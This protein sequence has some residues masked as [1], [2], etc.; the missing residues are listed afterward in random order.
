M[1]GQDQYAGKTIMIFGAGI[2]QLELIKSARDMVI[3][4][5]VVDPQ[6][7]PPGKDIA[8]FYY[9]I[10]ANDYETTREIAV[11]HKI[12]GLVTTQMEKP[13]RLM[14]RLAEDLGLKFHSA[15]VV[16]RSLDKW[17]MKQAFLQHRVP[18]AHGKLFTLE[19]QVKEMDLCDFQYPLILKPKDGTS[20][21]GV[22]RI[23]NYADIVKYI[24][25]TH[26]YS[27]NG[28]VLIEEFIEGPEYSIESITFNG[29]TTI[30]QYTEKMITPFP[31]TVEMGH[32]QPADLTIQQKEMIASVVK[33]AIQAIGIDNSAAHTEVK[34]TKDGPKVLEIGA[35][36]GGDLI[37]SFLTFGSTGVSMDKAMIQIALN[38]Q[39]DLE[40]K[41]QSYSHIKYFEL[42]VGKK[43]LQVNDW[44]DVLTESTL[45][46][47]DISVKPGDMIEEITES[48]KRPGFVI[49]KGENRASVLNAA[50]I[51]CEKL[52]LKV[53]LNGID[54]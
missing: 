6:T 38:E 40:S 39:P 25:V 2:N 11:R 1:Y 36:G 51:L 41:Q 14:A 27:R 10:Q 3:V 28:E 7:N 30:I 50:E 22:Y 46:Y 48:K 18:C 49:V 26:C 20:S 4:S 45:V 32:L 37:S 13:L 33:S 15:E 53:Q 16:E 31:H 54:S 8:D 35:R 43:V 19:K 34:L 5:V 47:A 17:L 23:E 52:K 9:C 24:D 21:Q 12:D 44:Q 42:P 29:E